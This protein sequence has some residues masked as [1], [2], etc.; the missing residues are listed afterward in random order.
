MPRSRKITAVAALFGVIAL[1]LVFVAEPVRTRSVS[2]M[3]TITNGT[4]IL[5]N[6]LAYRDTLPQRGDIVMFDREGEDSMIKR[7][8]GLPGDEV[9]IEDGV[10]VVNKVELTEPYV[11]QSSI[12]GNYYGPVVVPEGM[13]FVMGD[14]R[15]ESVDSREFG[16]IPVDQLVGKAD[17]RLWPSPGFLK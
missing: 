8:V 11:D 14:N 6:K 5:V 10:L 17:L 16:P 13:L 15:S 9:G 1:I 3:P 4:Q 2:M 12:D 7:V